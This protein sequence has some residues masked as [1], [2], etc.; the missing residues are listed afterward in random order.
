[1]KKHRRHHGGGAGPGAPRAP[2][3]QVQKPPEKRT[4]HKAWITAAVIVLAGIGAYAKFGLKGNST[5]ANVPGT[6]APPA[7]APTAIASPAPPRAPAPVTGPRAQFAST[8]YDFGKANGDDF[9][10]CRFTYTNTGIATLE[11]SEVSPGC[12]CMKVQDWTRKL[13]PGQS[14]V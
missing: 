9:V 13:E 5:A 7:A 11:L 10:D 14:G 1:K 3:Y 4:N 8:T 2:I 6:T 12:G